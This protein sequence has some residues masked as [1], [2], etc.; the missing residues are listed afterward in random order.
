MRLL[1][2]L[3]PLGLSALCL[4][5]C[6][7]ISGT[8]SS[9]PASMGPVRLTT[10]ICAV[11]SPSCTAKSNSGSFYGFLSDNNSDQ[12]VPMQVLFGVR[13]PEGTTPP[14]DLTATV[15]GGTLALSRNAS[16]EARLQAFEPA[17]AG[18]RWWGWLSATYVYSRSSAQSLA[19]TVET[20]LPRPADGGAYP[21]PMHWRSVVGA[22]EVTAG[23]PASRPVACGTTVEDFYEGFNEMNPDNA[24][25][26][27]VC[28]DSPDPSG[29]RGYLEAPVTDFGL[30]AGAV[31]KAPP[32]STVGVVLQAVRTG[33]ADPSTTF[34]LTVTGGPPGAT[35]TLDRTTAPLG[36]DA[37]QPVVASVAVPPGT[38]AGDYPITLDATAPGKP[39]RTVTAG[40]SVVPV[41]VATVT[42]T[43]TA[44]P[45]AVPDTTKPRL[46][47][48]TLRHRRVRFTLSEAATVTVR[49]GA[50]RVRRALPAGMGRLRLPRGKGRKVR[51]SAVDAAGN[52]S[53]TKTL[54]RR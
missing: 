31:T 27:V 54:R 14:D 53:A 34:A 51:V 36:G 10:T 50:R 26:S 16:Y 8:T 41:P 37:A 32:G 23:F 45:T 1:A 44:T 46:G 20:A 4:T 13:L 30:A 33:P 5:G 47:K 11:G 38:P 35:V 25:P 39:S 40:F 42:P 18:E 28:L 6:V 3:L 2:R 52:R 15:G 7:G 21:S 12:T 19:V 43:A 17:P 22:R 48:V 29:A 49:V 9:Q 24:A